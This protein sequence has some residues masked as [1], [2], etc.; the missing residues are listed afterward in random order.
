[1]GAGDN[2]QEAEEPVYF[3][4][5]G[6][7]I[8]IV[9]ATQIERST[10]YTKEATDSS[11]GVLKTLNPQKYI[12]VIEKAKANADYV[13]CYVHWGTEGKSTYEAD[14][15]ALAEAFIAAGADAIVGGHTH[16]LQGVDVLDGVPIFYSLGN[17]YFSQEVE[18]PADYNTG[19]A[20]LVIQSDG[21]LEARFLPCSFSEGV[22]SLLDAGQ[23][24]Q[25]ILNQLTAISDGDTFDEE[26]Y[27]IAR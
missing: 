12:Q 22:L 24:Y 23:Q 11:A 2:L 14:Q 19:V 9:A 16:C 18:M 5:N 7:K 21:T 3:I 26:G 10:N 4:A 25:D 1:V 27:I 6:R 15:T 13:I 17:F 8:A 20:Q